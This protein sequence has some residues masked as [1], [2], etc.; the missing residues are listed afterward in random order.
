MIVFFFTYGYIVEWQSQ[1]I[2]YVLLLHK[3]DPFYG[4]N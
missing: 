4:K 2:T 3:L 1:T